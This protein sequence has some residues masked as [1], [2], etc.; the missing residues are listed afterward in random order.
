[1]ENLT[2]VGMKEMSQKI[3]R[4]ERSLA[5]IAKALETLVKIENRKNGVNLQIEDYRKHTTDI[6]VEEDENDE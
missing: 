3:S 6:D 5:D 2:I 4:M 1:M